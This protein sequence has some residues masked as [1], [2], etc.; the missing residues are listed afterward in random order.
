MFMLTICNLQR[1]LL[2]VQKYMDYY[3]HLLSVI[4]PFTTA[5]E[6]LAD[7]RCRF[8]NLL[9]WHFASV[10]R[11]VRGYFKTHWLTVH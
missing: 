10:E 4:T 7:C 8:K 3:G 5:D 6:A 1:G 2:E 9:E 11:L